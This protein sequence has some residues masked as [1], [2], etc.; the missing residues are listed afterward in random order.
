MSIV[1]A[2]CLV[3]CGQSQPPGV[4]DGGTTTE[5]TS[6]PPD[7][8]QQ[9][10]DDAGDDPTAEASPD[11]APE[12]EALE[13]EFQ[14]R[15]GVSAFDTGTG[16]AVEYRAD[17]RFGYA[18]TIKAFV[19]AEFLGQMPVEERDTHVTWTRE[20]VAAAGY[21]PVT[22][23]RVDDGLTWEQL[24][25]AAVRQSDNAATNLVLD[26]IGGAEGLG[27]GLA[28][29]GDTVTHV[30]NH[31][32]ALNV[33]RLGSTDDTTTPA[34]FTA[35]FAALL[36]PR[37]LVAED[38][39]ILLDWMRGNATGDALIRAGAPDGWIVADK[40]GGAGGMRNDIAL[41]TPPGRAPIVITVLTQKIDPEA[42]YQD[43][44]VA[45]V[46]EVVLFAL[47]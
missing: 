42:R 2:A 22:G 16:A 47:H 11:V 1:T 25:E 33:I 10:A 35:S 13:R 26:R 8:A 4:P 41:V 5:V 14:A 36:Q 43:E 9:G 37:N 6:S 30:V 34:A 46:A 12:L 44:L 28:K 27:A 45:G 31:E 29:L 23:E 21:S 38:L 3:A 20:D 18:S 39:T 19:A 7:G 32:P 17:E 40:S 24:A 15:V